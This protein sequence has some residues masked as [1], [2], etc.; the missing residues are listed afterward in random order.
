MNV[1]SACAVTF[2]RGL[3]LWLQTLLSARPQ[4]LPVLLLRPRGPAQTPAP[5]WNT[6]QSLGEATGLSAT[7]CSWASPRPAPCIPPP[8]VRV[9]GRHRK[10]DNPTVQGP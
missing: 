4:P 3:C 6:E 5:S 8:L 2:L 9:H 10:G 7:P 1:L